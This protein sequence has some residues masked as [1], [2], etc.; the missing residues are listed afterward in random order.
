MPLLW[1]QRS[2]FGPG[3]RVFPALAYDSKRGRLVLFGGASQ[4]ATVFGDTWEWDG[5]YWTQMDD[6]GPAPRS[7]H[8]MAY[9][10]NRQVTLLF[11]GAS[12]AANKNFGDTWKWDGEDWT[13]LADSGPI[14]R[15]SHAMAFDLG[16]GRALLFGGISSVG[17][18]GIPNVLQ[19][20]WEFDGEAWT[21]QED[22]GP[23]A[24]GSHTMAYDLSSGRVVLF[25][26]NPARDDTWAWDGKTWVQIAEFGPPGRENAAMT[27]SPAGLILF[28]G[29]ASQAVFGDS[30]EFDGKHWTQKQ[31]IGP[32]ARMGQALAFDSVRN[33][34]V[35]FGG[36]AGSQGGD[37]PLLFRDTWECPP[38]PVSVTS[39]QFVPN[40]ATVGQSIGCTLT[41]SHA[42]LTPT[43]V[44]ITVEST[45]PAF[46][47][48]SV[49]IPAELTTFTA[50]YQIPQLIL[51]GAL[52]VTVS[53]QAAGTPPASTTLTITP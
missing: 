40:P 20:T 25:G 44:Q 32:A 34:L 46:T 30:W 26:G 18:D 8:A 1:T 50:P 28:G 27:G 2:N 5:S 13:Q 45:N 24:R 38:P 14:P 43:I 36:G 49:T 35:M 31:D 53:A 51:N 29:A 17:A 22:V 41:L 4:P 15:F 42:V 47:S 19:D 52:E 6:I 23:A 48:V 21:Q 9:D 37:P 12:G 16:R 7:G 39:L 10:A 11:G 3:P 33:R